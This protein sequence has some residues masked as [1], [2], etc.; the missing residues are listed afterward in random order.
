MNQIL[1]LLQILVLALLFAG[2]TVTFSPAQEGAVKA[3][4]PDCEKTTSLQYMKMSRHAESSKEGIGLVMHSCLDHGAFIVT[5]E[6]GMGHKLGPDAMRRYLHLYGD[7]Y[8]IQAVENITP[9]LQA[10]QGT[11]TTKELNA[12]G[13]LQALSC[14]R[15]LPGDLHL[16]MHKLD[17]V[18]KLFYGGFLQPFQ[19]VLRWKR[20]QMDPVHGKR[21]GQSYDLANVVY[22]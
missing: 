7:R 20:I 15:F 12:T 5:R 21:F 9:T 13:Y 4:N 6:D 2:L 10:L 11:S 1:L 22:R 8:S 14:V 18:F 3:W 19:A 16:L 17:V